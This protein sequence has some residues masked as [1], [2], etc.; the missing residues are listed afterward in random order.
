[1]PQQAPTQGTR[2]L[3]QRNAG[4]RVLNQGDA[5]LYTQEGVLGGGINTQGKVRGGGEQAKTQL[6]PTQLTQREGDAD[7][8]ERVKLANRKGAR[9]NQGKRGRDQLR[10]G[11]KNTWGGAQEGQGVW[12]RS[13]HSV[14]KRIRLLAPGE[15]EAS[16]AKQQCMD[17]VAIFTSYANHGG[18]LVSD[19]L[20]SDTGKPHL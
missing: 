5:A 8:S 17:A 20:G 7:G 4:G 2:G 19:P 14:D 10:E 1:M 6:K 9:Q 11:D 18:V 13:R 12:T 16:R 15:E 3:I